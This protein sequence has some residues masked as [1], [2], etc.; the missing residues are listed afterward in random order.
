MWAAN[1]HSV[2]ARRTRRCAVLRLTDYQIGRDALRRALAD[3]L[4]NLDA[5]W[6]RLDEGAIISAYAN[7]RLLKLAGEDAEA[8][9]EAMMAALGLAVASA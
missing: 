8:G 6:A 4:A 5:T 1:R 7:V 3:V 9:I 2:G